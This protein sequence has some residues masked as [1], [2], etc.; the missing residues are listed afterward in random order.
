[1]TLD[2][3]HTARDVSVILLAIEFMVLAAVPL[4][5]LYFITRGLRH[6]VRKARPFLRQV[7]GYGYQ[8][9][10]AIDKGLNAIVRPFVWLHV[11]YAALTGFW[12]RWR[13][14]QRQ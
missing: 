5:I 14:A 7:A 1:M 4:V 2:V 12:R 10:E 11:Q 3:L 9:F 13:W 8:G 6:V